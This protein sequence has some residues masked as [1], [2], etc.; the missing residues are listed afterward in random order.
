[1]N[2]QSWTTGILRRTTRS[3]ATLGVLSL[4]A[5]LAGCPGGGGTNQK[6]AGSS[7]NVRL[8]S[9]SVTPKS[10]FVP[11]GGKE[12]MVATGTYSDG[13]TKPLTDV[14]WS[15]DPAG[16]V[17][18]DGAVLTA[19]GVGKAT[20]TATDNTTKLAGSTDVTVTLEQLVSIRIEQRPALTP[21]STT[22]LVV[23]GTKVQLAAVG[24]YTDDSEHDVTAMVSWH[25]DTPSVA[26][27]DGDSML[28]GISVGSATLSANVGSI[29]GTAPV[30][31]IKKEMV[32]LALTPTTM[33]TPAGLTIPLTATATY[34]N[35]MS[36]SINSLVTWS[37]SD[38]T[39]ATVDAAG[40]VT[41][42]KAG[43]P[44]TITAAVG[45][46]ADARSATSSITCDAAA[47]LSDAN[48]HPTGGL[49]LT[50]EH[51]TVCAGSTT[52]FTLTANY[53]DGTQKILTVDSSA[54]WTSSRPSSATV[55]ATGSGLVT[56][57]ATG[58]A[59]ISV[60]VD[61][62]TATASAIVTVNAACLVSITVKRTDD[63]SGNPSTLSSSTPKGVSVSYVATGTYTD[64]TTHDLTSSASPGWTSSD[65]S[66]SNV[67]FG[68]A[69]A[70][71]EGTT[72]ITV[73]VTTAAGGSVSA[74]TTLTVSPAEIVSIA[75]T[76]ATQK[77]A[78]GE[79]KQFTA[80]GTYTDNST[81]DITSTVTW[82]SA[83]DANVTVSSTGVATG[84]LQSGA[85]VAITA[86]KDAAAGSANVTVIPPTLKSITITAINGQL[87][88]TNG[89]LEVPKG[90]TLALV[91]TGTNTDGTPVNLS[92]VTW[93]STNAATAT[94]SGGG[95]VHGITQGT[96]TISATALNARNETITGT[97]QIAVTPPI[98]VSILLTPVNASV[99][100]GS[101][102]QL[103]ATAVYSDDTNLPVTTQSSWTSSDGS[104]ATIGTGSGLVQSIAEGIT[105]VV[106][107][108]TGSLA[109]PLVS[110][111]LTVTVTPHQLVSLEISPPSDLN[112]PIAIALGDHQQFVVMGT[113]TD[114]L[115]EELTTMV[116]WSSTNPSV[117]SID[118]SGYVT[119]VSS[120]PTPV[121]IEAVL[122]TVSATGAVL[123]NPHALRTI[124]I[125]PLN[126]SLPLGTTM[127]LVATGHY[128]DGATS[129]I[130]NSVLW[131]SEDET[132]ASVDSSGVVYSAA[133]GIV[134]VTATFDDGVDAPVQ[135]FT[136]VNVAPPALLSIEV[137]VPVDSFPLG[138]SEQAVAMGTYTYGDPQDITALAGLQWTT[139][140]A[141]IATVSNASGSQGLVQSVGVGPF[142]LSATVGAIV[143]QAHLTVTPPEVV[144]ITIDP[145][146]AS[147]PVGRS[148][149]FT[150][151]GLYTNG[152]RSPVAASL[153]SSD[154]SIAGFDP[155]STTVVVG[156]RIGTAIITATYND[157]APVTATVTVTKPVL[158][159]I[160]LSSATGANGFPLGKTLQLIATG[161]YSDGTEPDL[162]ALATWTS[163]N[164]A[165]ATVDA[166]TGLVHGVTTGSSNVKATYQGVDGSMIVTVAPA[167]IVSIRVTPQNA[168]MALG[169]NANLTATGTFTDGTT[170]NITTSVLW[171]ADDTTVA[172]V[173]PTGEVRSAS[174]GTTFVTASRVDYSGNTISA[175]SNI[176]VNPAALVSLDLS[177]QTPVLA[178]GTY[179][180]MQ[181]TGTYTAGDP[182]DVTDQATWTVLPLNSPV[183][184]VT[185]GFVSA[186]GQGTCVVQ[187]KLNGITTST[188][189]TVTQAVLT[190]MFLTPTNPTIPLGSTVTMTATGLFT[191]STVG[192][193][194][195]AASW[196]TSAPLICTIVDTLGHVKGTGQGTCIVTVSYQGIV[197]STQVIV[198]AVQPSKIVV[199]PANVTMP[200]GT[201]K[202]L[203]AI[204]TFTDGT[205][206]DVTCLADWESIE[207]DYATVTNGT[208][209]P[210]GTISCGLVS[211]G[212]YAQQN[213][214][215]TATWSNF[216][217][218]SAIHITDATLV[219]VLI[220]PDLP[221]VKV[222]LPLDQQFNATGTFSDGSIRDVTDEG[223]WTSS[224]NSVVTVTN[225]VPV[226]GGSLCT[227]LYGCVQSIAQGTAQVS[228]TQGSV[229]TTKT[230]VVGDF[231][232]TDVIIEPV[233]PTS[234]DLA[235]LSLGD[236][237]ELQAFAKYSNG[238]LV[239]VTSDLT[240]SSNSNTTVTFPDPSV[241]LLVTKARGGTTINA[242]Y[243]GVTGHAAVFVGPVSLKRIEITPRDPTLYAG[244]TLQLLVTG[245]KSDG[246][247]VDLTAAT[248]WDTEE[249]LVAK[250]APGGV[251]KGYSEGT[252]HIT[253]SASGKTDTIYVTV[254]PP[255]LVQIQIIRREEQNPI[256][257]CSV[258]TYSGPS[259]ME[260]QFMA[261]ARYSD[262]V[263]KE[264][265]ANS[266][267]AIL[268]VN[269]DKAFGT[270][271]DTFLMRT[272]YGATGVITVQAAYSGVTGTVTITIN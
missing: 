90:L 215:I 46:G 72:T 15:N 216:T 137:Q 261:I 48:G 246:S 145:P 85:A 7:T 201:T 136:D 161:H 115:T 81:K 11:K 267:W 54:H 270:L 43:G 99:P 260:F 235:A 224:N 232:V 60:T 44:I 125:T 269:T 57:R 1:V 143:G 192:D 52:Q 135:G 65:T 209:L 241:G 121:T 208:M 218:S 242:A 110:T 200:L 109:T 71:A 197:V 19:E 194:T 202:Q 217:A 162:S 63:M 95:I 199:Q 70:D 91:A 259:G 147:L 187:A 87:P 203:K 177:P 114:Q 134:H 252:S 256:P 238:D 157:V 68:A 89:A 42:L 133:E 263:Y 243:Q 36:E 138:L 94:V 37:S 189:V 264:V 230:V 164:V 9:V 62:T 30:S 12:T 142:T 221:T 140:A 74:S 262:G 151:V 255:Q 184:S 179:V 53:T 141:A 229:S 105:Q 130:T 104:I 6:D 206:Q 174:V 92:G 32:Q 107:T 253:A 222:N 131:H 112:N 188:T 34:N 193:V 56:T 88:N 122:G 75:V 153:T 258:T 113:Y 14:A 2:T 190:S 111:P 169:R 168:S 67:V 220:T 225:N 204:A 250:V 148:Q 17:T 265:T 237:P 119:S 249:S 207:P 227:D 100:L 24:K 38:T 93:S 198:G 236:K 129:V 16:I 80:T 61:G 73:T 165:V 186:T 176:T 41:C 39:V 3:G 118:A 47:I 28:S 234:Y 171:T 191:D 64:G 156:N 245:Y 77:L 127:N 86:K 240:W 211:T 49:V 29:A 13:S 172:T 45:A 83:S 146:T 226:H 128:S 132:V 101:T 183:C 96:V 272:I 102:L 178:L 27:V 180:Q 144:S 268:P 10:S 173:E 210:D 23:E 108:Y 98:P 247:T 150:V 196:T 251:L 79:T 154:E 195:Q 254:T 8:E 167:D 214:T 123:V 228:F 163:D 158:D 82:S 182:Q 18:L 248:T 106:A 149:N 257:T 33:N 21:P 126:P 223:H 5:F 166:S 271:G 35:D 185:F 51:P 55:P 59:T 22:L 159:Y 233:D 155:S 69:S 117:A 231:I 31:V 20:V 78:V 103:T 40:I 4:V 116:A 181:L 239:L 66:V 205:T 124:D 244:Q 160:L 50:P 25:S 58:N 76:P 26:T 175:V 152:S 120:S 213:T 170:Q 212:I 97:V 139:N 266:S 219:S 84:V